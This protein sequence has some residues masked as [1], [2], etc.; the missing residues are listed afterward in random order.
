MRRPT[1]F[2]SIIAGKRLF[3][4]TLALTMKNSNRIAFYDFYDSL[5]CRHMHSYANTLQSSKQRERKRSD[6]CRQKHCRLG[7]LVKKP[8]LP[9]RAPL[10]ECQRRNTGKPFTKPVFVAIRTLLELW[11]CHGGSFTG[12]GVA[13]DV[14]RREIKGLGFGNE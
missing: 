4:A 3:Q 11:L 5:M 2:C 10:V 7:G 14:D 6:G 8:S 9:A 1:T 13:A 12:E